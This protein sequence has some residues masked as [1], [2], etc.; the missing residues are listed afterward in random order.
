MPDHQTMQRQSAP[1]AAP[2]RA[3]AL[4]EQ[5]S[6]EA[7]EPGELVVKVP[8]IGSIDQA[9]FG[10]RVGQL[11]AERWAVQP[12]A[13]SQIRSVA[14]HCQPDGS[15]RNL[16]LLI[17]YD[18]AEDGRSGGGDGRIDGLQMAR[19]V[20]EAIADAQRGLG[21]AE[22]IDRRILTEVAQAQVALE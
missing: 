13:G 5:R 12:V 19:H 7:V 9:D 20:S 1:I 17:K 2:R 4:W 15:R 22:P 8:V 6:V 11:L 18:A 21:P 10:F 3:R 14:G 16:L